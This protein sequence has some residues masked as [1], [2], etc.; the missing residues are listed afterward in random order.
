MKKLKFEKLGF[1]L[2]P[3]GGMLY[4][5]KTVKK[6]IDYL[7][8]LD[9]NTLYMDFTAGYAIEG[10]PFFCY[11]KAKYTKEEFKELDDYALSKSITI[12]PTIQTLAHLFYLYRWPKNH[13]LFDIDDILMVDNPKVYELIDG[14]IKTMS[15]NFSCK[16]IHLG[17]DEAFRLG[18]GKYY[19]KY[20]P[21]DRVEIMKK[22]LDKVLQICKKYGVKAE[23]WADMFITMAYGN[24]TGIAEM[25]S[26]TKSVGNNTATDMVESVRNSIPKDIKLH[27]WDYYSLDKEHYCAELDKMKSIT[28]NIAFDGGIWNYISFV[29]DNTYS[30]KATEAAF[31]ACYEKGIKEVSVTTWAGDVGETSIWTIMPSVVAASEFSHGNHDMNKIKARFKKLMGIEFDAFIALENINK[32]KARDEKN[33]ESYTLSPCKYLLYNDPFVGIYD[34]TVYR[35][36]K[37]IFVDTVQTL[38]KWT[39]HKKWGYIFKTVQK[40]A[41]ILAY[42]FDLGLVTRELYKAGDKDNLRALANGTYTKIIKLLKEFYP[43]FRKQWY[44]EYMHHHFEIQDYR[45]GGIV[46]RMENCRQM[47][48]DY[49]DGKYERLDELEEKIVDYLDGT[50]EFRRGAILENGFNDEY[51]IL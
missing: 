14:M 25:F 47:L 11:L 33:T 36:E 27:Y 15:E 23:I 3:T 49:C 16:I 46:K 22:H 51:S 29:P 31:E 21:V 44:S 18:R 40:L 48:I 50:D 8:E 28:D 9:Y 43:L 24:Y 37:H 1:L 42:K 7:S 41:E 45:F 35:D 32:L 5:V 20:G 30:I 17:M 19:D 13:E 38:K 2:S 12:I 34:S 39:K 4:N 26:D 6:L 10:Q